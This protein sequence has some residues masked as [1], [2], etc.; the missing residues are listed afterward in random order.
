MAGY[1][2]QRYF[3]VEPA[4]QDHSALGALE[5]RV[6]Q[7][8]IAYGLKFGQTA[9]EY[10]GT[11]VTLI[12]GAAAVGVGPTIDIEI[13]GREDVVLVYFEALAYNPSV[14]NGTFSAYLYDSVSNVYSGLGSKTLASGVTEN[15]AS[16]SIMSAFGILGNLSTVPRGAQL[17]VVNYPP[18][19]HSLRMYW[20]YTDNAGALNGTVDEVYLSIDVL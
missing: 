12:D 2:V 11:A 13:G 10:S 8:E 3:G 9:Y 17:M 7:L 15:L 18:G 1:P 14:G 4:E 6:D 20:T 16:G 5:S 19:A